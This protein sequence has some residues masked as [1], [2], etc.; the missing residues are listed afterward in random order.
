MSDATA[1]GITV[2][3]AAGDNGSSDGTTDGIN[4]CDYPASSRYALG[5]GGTRLDANPSTG[6]I[7]SE[8]V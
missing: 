1:L 4:H 8:T 3:V 6:A 7:S 2:T 5:C